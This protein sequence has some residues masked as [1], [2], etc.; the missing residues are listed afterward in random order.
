MRTT[1]SHARVWANAAF[2]ASVTTRSVHLDCASAGCPYRSGL[3]VSRK[4]PRH[5]PLVQRSSFHATA[6]RPMETPASTA[7]DSIATGLPDRTPT[8]PSFDGFSITKITPGRGADAVDWLLQDLLPPTPNRTSTTPSPFSPSK[9]QPHHPPSIPPIVG[10]HLLSLA[11]TVPHAKS[12]IEYEGAYIPPLT[13]QTSWGPWPWFSPASTTS[14]SPPLPP[15]DR[16]DAEI[17]AFA[18]YIQPTPAERTARTHVIR[19]MSRVLHSLFP[20]R[21]V[22][23]FGSEATGLSAAVSD[24]DMNLGLKDAE[25]RAL[26]NGTMTATAGKEKLRSC[27]GRLK[28]V[29]ER[30]GEWE[31]VEIHW[32]RYPLVD[33]L[34]RPSGLKVQVTG[35]LVPGA[36]KRQMD[37]VRQLLGGCPAL[38][39][40]F[41]VLRTTLEVRGLMTV[42]EG[43]M[44]SYSLF[45]MAAACSQ[46]MPDMNPAQLLMKVLRYWHQNNTY[47][48]G[49][50]VLPP[51]VIEKGDPKSKAAKTMGKIEKRSLVDPQ[52]PYL[53]YLQDPADPSNDLGFKAIAIKHIRTTFGYLLKR[54]EHS[55]TEH[56]QGR[57]DRPMLVTMVGACEPIYKKER[58]L[59]ER[60]GASSGGL[61]ASSPK[62][63]LSPIRRFRPTA[64]GG[65]AADFTA[66]RF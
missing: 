43:G 11:T 58:V 52:Y 3:D 51:G 57:G 22:D 62:S 36:R 21:P 38:R 35:S 44:G 27:L 32:A 41:L 49:A 19:A 28:D 37:A 66:L 61:E 42:H 17:R 30:S 5:G 47:K 60:F 20:A 34:H 18:A 33:A 9:P 8:L 23:T 45:M 16:L 59:L 29:L 65:L 4:R 10:R 40:V 6:R 25:R 54:L 46:M 13:A 39:E 31:G 2:D 56:E 64:M 15:A 53:L 1:A 7:E 55:L 48:Y 50:S 26:E 24:I 63:N 14:S 12:P